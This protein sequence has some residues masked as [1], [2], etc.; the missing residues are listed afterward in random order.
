MSNLRLNTLVPDVVNNAS[1]TITLPGSLAVIAL[2]TSSVLEASSPSLASVTLQGGLGIAKNIALSGN[3]LF[4]STPS[5]A[6]LVSQNTAAGFDNSGIVI[7]GG[8][9][10]GASRGASIE[11]YGNQYN[12]GNI[13]L[14]TGTTGTLTIANG[15]FNAATFSTVGGLT[16]NG[17]QSST[18]AS[19]G[20]L[21]LASGGLTVNNTQDASSTTSGGAATIAGGLAVKASFY[22]GGTTSLGGNTTNNG[23]LNVKS[24]LDSTGL[25]TGS[26]YTFGGAAIGQSLYVGSTG[27]FLAGIAVAGQIVST[28]TSDTAINL[29]GGITTAK[30][31]TVNGQLVANS[32]VSV[33]G[34]HTVTNATDTTGSTNGA[35]TVA[36]GAG[37][38][39]SLNVGNNITGGGNFTLSSASSSAT[40]APAVTISNAS[41]SSALGQGALIV[42]NGGMSVMKSARFGSS[43]FVGG[44]STVT[45]LSSLSSVSATGN[46]SISS[47]TPSVDP[48]SGALVVSGGFGLI[49]AMNAAGIVTLSNS[50]DSN[51]V[52]TGTLIL[53]NGGLGV[54]KAVNIGTMLSVGGASTFTGS[55]TAAAVTM[56]GI[57]TNTNTTASTNTSTGSAFF[58]GGVVVSGNL[59][60]AANLSIAGTTT[61][62]GNAAFAGVLTNSN[63]TEAS[64][65]SLASSVLQGGLSVNKALRVGGNQFVTGNA[66]VGGTLSCTNSNVSSGPSSGAVV[67]TGGVGIGGA[68][69]VGGAANVTGSATFSSTSSFVGIATFSN[70]TEATSSAGSIVVSGGISVAKSIYVGIGLAVM[71]SSTLAGITAGGIVNVTNNTSSSAYNNGAVV[72][73]GGL[74]VGNNINCAGNL[75]VTGS[76]AVGGVTT[77]TNPTDASA[78]NTAGTI[79]SGGVSVTKNLIVGGGLNVTAA[80]N[81]SGTI[82]TSFGS[83]VLNTVSLSDSSGIINVQST[84]PALRIAAT[85]A[86]KTT[87]YSNS[88]DVFS[89]GN[90]YTDGNYESLQFTTTSTNTYTIQSRAAGTGIVR[91][92]LLQSGTN[93]NQ[94][95]LNN[96]G[97]VNLGST[98]TDSTTTNSGSVTISGGLGVQGSISIGKTLRMF[99]STSGNIAISAPATVTTYSLMLPNAVAPAANYALVSDTSGNLSWSQMITPNPSFQSVAITNATPSTTT[100]T[101]ALV[102][103]NGGLGVAGAGNFGGSMSIAGNITLA[104]AAGANQII[105]NITGSAAPSFTTRST[106]TRFVV[107][108]TLSG[109]SADYAI[110]ITSGYLW[111]S[112]DTTSHG[113]KWYAGTSTVLT[114]DGNGNLTQS[115]GAS[116]IFAG[117]TSGT[118]TFKPPATVTSYTLT[119]PAS[120]PIA[121]NYALVSDT[122]GKLSFSQM[123]TSDPTFNTVTISATTP[124]T[125]LNTGAL[126]LSGGASVGAALSLKGG[127]RLVAPTS[128]VVSIAVPDNNSSPTFTLP[129]SAPS[130]PGQI[131]T[132]DSAGNL[133]WA[134]A[135]TTASYSQSLNNNVT[136]ATVV[137]GLS[138][139]GNNMFKIDVYVAL[140]TNTGTMGAMY[141][142]RGLKSS[143]GWTLSATYVGDNTGINFSIDANGNIMYTS[144]NVAN[145]TGTTA[146]WTGPQLYSAPTGGTPQTATGNNNQSVAANVS[147]LIVSPPQFTQYVLVTVNNTTTASSTNT[148]YLLQ[149]VQQQS[150]AWNFSA[151]IV[152]GPDPGIRFGI[153][154]SGQIQYTSG[155]ISGWLSTTFTFTADVVPL[156]NT[157]SYVSLNV[158][159]TT[160]ATSTTTGALI[161]SGGI[162]SGANVYVGGNVNAS[163]APTTGAHLSNKTYVDGL[164]YLTAGTGLTKV[165]STISVNASQITSVGTLTGLTSS[166]IVNISNATN[167]T[168]VGTGALTVSG[169]ISSGGSIYLSGNVNASTAPTTG[170]HLTN[171]TYVDGLSYLTAGTGLTLTGSTLNVDG[172]Q[173]GITSLG[174]LTGLTSSGVVN[175]TNTTNSTSVGTGALT[176]SGGIS[177]GANV[178]V[179]GNVS[180]STAPAIGS[181]L[182]NK[183]YVDGLS[184]LTAGTG[185]TLTGSTLNVNATQNS[186]TSVGTLT[187]L[188]SSGIVSVTSTVV[189]SSATS[190]ALQ[191]SGGVGI[192]GNLYVGGYQIVGLPAGNS[193]TVGNMLGFTGTAGDT[194]SLTTMNTCLVERIYGGTE[195]SELLIFKGNDPA[196]TSGPDVVRVAAAEFYV[197][198]LASGSYNYSTNSVP[199]TNRKLTITN[200][201]ATFADQI[202]LLGS[203]PDIPNRLI[204]AVSSN[205][206][207]TQYI[208]FGNAFSN[209][210]SAELQFNYSAAGSASNMVSLGMYGF[211]S[212]M[213]YGN[214][215]MNISSQTVNLTSTTDSTSTTS[216]ALQVA[217]GI[218]LK[219]SLVIGTASVV[220]G[221]L[222]KNGYNDPTN[223]QLW[224]TDSTYTTNATNPAFRIGLG[225]GTAWIGAVSTD[226]ST[227]LPLNVSSPM[228][229]TNTSDATGSGQ[230]GLQ[231][232]GGV[233][234]SKSVYIGSSGYTANL[235][236]ANNVSGNTASSVQIS[237]D[238]GS[239]NLVLFLN[240]STR[241]VDGGPYTGTLRND[242]GDLWLSAGPVYNMNLGIRIVSTTNNV[243][244]TSTT[245]SISTTTGAFQVA[246][247]IGLQKSM[248]VGG[249]VQITGGV[250]SETAAGINRIDIGLNGTPRILL[251]NSSGKIWE[252]DSDAT[253]SFRLF[254]PGKGVLTINGTTFD[255][256]M[257]STTDSSSTTNGALRVSGGC[258]FGKSLYVGTAG[259]FGFSYALQTQTAGS[260]FYTP[261]TSTLTNSTL[262]LFTAVNNGGNT[263]D[264][265]YPVLNMVKPGQYGVSWDSTATFYLNRYIISG[266]NGASELQLGLSATQQT[267]GSD[268]ST[269]VAK[270]RADGTNILSGSLQITNIGIATP[271][272][273]G[274]NAGTRIT[275]FPGGIEANYGQGIE[276]NHIWY[277]ASDHAG[278][279]YKWYWGTS[280]SA[281]LAQVGTAGDPV[282]QIGGNTVNSNFTDAR[283]VLQDR[284]NGLI[285]F[286]YTGNKIGSIT[287]NGSSTTYNTTSDYRLKDPLGNITDPVERVINLKP[288]RFKWRESGVKAEGFFAHEVADVLPEAVLGDKDAMDDQGRPVHQQL[289]TT[290][291]IPLLTAAIQEL[292]KELDK[293]KDRIRHCPHCLV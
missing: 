34:I 62:T 151:Q 2:S 16:L 245:D 94:V 144:T 193:S 221:I 165:G 66:S 44:A 225:T 112:A 287:T 248:Y 88:V 246:G 32:N 235:R 279:G 278:T 64:S 167:S 268:P 8:G 93:S 256:N 265:P 249:H 85:N 270:W 286:Y 125:G 41:D 263:A 210:N 173:T 138:F 99:G 70:V 67:V 289:D 31:I 102:L 192:K 196:G 190:G 106:G 45:G 219:K 97:T 49:G 257:S 28:S 33:S 5:T 148:L 153:L 118:V 13:R 42:S 172:A 127:L 108:P 80:S 163:T 21:I 7:A 146:S 23:T 73:T 239:N 91:R 240:S 254:Q 201:R 71:G 46:V 78:L 37:I 121:S 142:L 168:S 200:S 179:G 160:D 24:T 227:T 243:L 81:F 187:G 15:A 277:Q 130:T 115:P 189:S 117:S 242:A 65:L 284:N 20:A 51:A 59:N 143:T 236:I 204:A 109:S 82:T 56:S 145:W 175:I 191:V 267:S 83:F 47:V 105:S 92:L 123:V 199:A 57:F 140:V 48:N 183:T 197:D 211:Q 27:N 38:A 69:N 72:V 253:G 271:P 195:S 39:L 258:G 113:H 126:V 264:T 170:A 4:A 260:T 149:G 247:G 98:T 184:Y 244:V 285:S 147:G 229:I 174:T 25:A 273:T 100:S 291:L 266:S 161:V 212:I 177:S 292:K 124:N 154:S 282:M 166:G 228:I 9:A 14:T 218:G 250:V 52:T 53:S 275:Y 77:F 208:S 75:T 11:L 10:L 185:L 54:A 122:S 224:L 158:T 238:V 194:S 3:I 162:S 60:L 96:D 26:F 234:I 79:F 276:N 18:S 209:A 169:G 283:L 164:S 280:C 205:Y 220:D 55:V 50:T 101:G 119:L 19:T 141:T 137:P 35:L 61:L 104:G 132:S 111:Y 216:G 181:H 269:I 226:G 152:S 87:Q 213:I 22:V 230:G 290:K 217:G 251:E 89:L 36:G 58:Y 40:I 180:A 281:R 223:R 134:N 30:G 6:A 157:V 156:Q 272:A 203:V 231:V 29:S 133:Q 261:G 107:S 63:T 222:I 171:K 274:T 237:P 128:G 188:T 252:I 202:S 12:S 262:N 129:S 259:N 135:P 255:V 241:A 76:T 155:N 198:T 103:T 206:T 215:T 86:A 233:G 95:V 110:G 17:T 43:V 139:G 90:V 68:I 1:G 150:G 186:I 293:V 232:S 84:A 176:V 136:T 178:Y 131:L 116:H 182:A 288:R 114:L 159:G 214:N 74:G 120:L 207:G